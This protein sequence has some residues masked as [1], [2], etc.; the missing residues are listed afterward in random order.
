MNTSFGKHSGLLHL[1]HGKEL[2]LALL[3]DLP[4]LAE[5]SLANGLQKHKV[6]PGHFLIV[7]KRITSNFWLTSDQVGFILYAVPHLFYF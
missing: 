2:S 1:L 5:S 4:D 6:F 7:C 3:S